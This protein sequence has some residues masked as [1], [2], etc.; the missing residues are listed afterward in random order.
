MLAGAL[1]LVIWQILVGVQY[2]P[3]YSRKLTYTYNM[4]IT[5]YYITDHFLTVEKQ[6]T[7]KF[8]W[9][10][11]SDYNSLLTTQTDFHYE[12]C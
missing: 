5:R 4:K 12:A 11:H 3:R 6:K 7:N 2:G 9:S 8:A 1:M 10:L